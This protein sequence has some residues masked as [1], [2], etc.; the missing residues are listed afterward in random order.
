MNDSLI[1]FATFIASELSK[2]GVPDKKLYRTGNMMA[3]IVPVVID[4]NT[5]D[6]II[7][8]DYA[9]FTNTRGKWAGWVEQN[10]E[11]CSRCYADNNDVESFANLT[12]EIF[13]GS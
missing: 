4:E 6:I 8:T 7:A 1:N 5:V 3:S 13:Y 12:G 10:I 11:R 2:V 9:S